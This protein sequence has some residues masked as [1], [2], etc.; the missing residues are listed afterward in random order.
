MAFKV[1]QTSVM[2]SKVSEWF[3][4]SYFNLAAYLVSIGSNDIEGA[5]VSGDVAVAPK[6][7]VYKYPVHVLGWVSH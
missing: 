2:K 1:L 4:Y 3:I 7:R 6:F 5:G